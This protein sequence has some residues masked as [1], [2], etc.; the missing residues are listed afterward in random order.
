MAAAS[1]G[2]ASGRVIAPGSS[3][4]AASSSARSSASRAGPVSSS[5]TA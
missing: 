1:E 4:K 3:L 2:E 5:I